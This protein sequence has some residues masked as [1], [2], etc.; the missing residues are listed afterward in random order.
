MLETAY[1][2]ALA[3]RGE[4]GSSLQAGNVLSDALSNPRC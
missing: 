2:G 4:D 3:V 1:A